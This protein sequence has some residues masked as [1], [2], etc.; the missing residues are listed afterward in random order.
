MRKRY[1]SRRASIEERKNIRQAF[2][3]GV[4]AIVGLIILVT[5]GLP[6]VAKFASFLTNIK[7]SELPVEQEDK[8]PPAPPRFDAFPE[9]T[10]KLS[11]EIN[12]NAEPGST[13]VLFLNQ[14]KEEV[15]TNNDGGFNYTFSLNK[16]KNTISALAKDNSGNESQKTDVLTVT[17]DNQ[18]PDLEIL[19]PED[20]SEFFG[21]RQRQITIE[22]KT[23]EGATLTINDRVVV[24]DENGDFVFT[25]SLSEGDNSF[26]I[27]SKDKSENITEKT[28]NLRFSP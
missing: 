25:K 15:I 23:E 6:L 24:V 3:F 22:G 5:F 17:F 16:G 7:Q 4:L 21:S 20:G 19:K 12:G 11:I 9:V 18:P 28:I 1:Y 2:L 26:L 10:N 8:T 27:K 14:K 13:V